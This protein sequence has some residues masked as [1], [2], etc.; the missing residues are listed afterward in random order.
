MKL[1]KLL[2]QHRITLHFTW[3]C[4]C[5]STW[6]VNASCHTFAAVL[7]H[8]NKS[9]P[10]F[11]GLLAAGRPRAPAAVSRTHVGP[12]PP[13]TSP[14]LRKRGGSG[15]CPAGARRRRHRGEAAESEEKD[16]TSDLLLKHSDETFTTCVWRQMKHL[17]HASEILEK[18]HENIWKSHWKTYAISR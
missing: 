3:I 15:G 10:K 13:R 9:I 6:Y 17:K 1:A 14:A 12:V 16:A 7:N 2:I 8:H 4:F 5:L 11:M 18:I